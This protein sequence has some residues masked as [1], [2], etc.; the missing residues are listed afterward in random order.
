MSVEPQK[1]SIENEEEIQAHPMTQTS[2]D[3]P[4]YG[5]KNLYGMTLDE[6]EESIQWKKQ[7][8]NMLY[9]KERPIK[10]KEN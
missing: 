8:L 4:A 6:L 9:K 7:F 3:F 10:Q 1:Q 5:S 2:R